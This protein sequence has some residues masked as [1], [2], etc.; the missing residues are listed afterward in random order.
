MG[1]IAWDAEGSFLAAEEVFEK[2]ELV[3]QSKGRNKIQGKQQV[4][5]KRVDP[6]E[7]IKGGHVICGGKDRRGLYPSIGRRLLAGLQ[8]GQ[9]RAAGGCENNEKEKRKSKECTVFF[10]NGGLQIF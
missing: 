10:H 9:C 7:R 1:K 6:G 2:A 3:F 4:S 5:I 8:T